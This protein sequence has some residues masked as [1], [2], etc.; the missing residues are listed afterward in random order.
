MQY[1][2]EREAKRSK[3]FDIKKHRR[4]TAPE[5]AAEVVMRYAGTRCKSGEW[6]ALFEL[7]EVVDVM[8]VDQATASRLKRLVIGDVVTVTA[9][10]SIKTRGRSR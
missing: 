6:L 7:G 3:G 1:V 5:K 4:Y 8:P 10:G 2:E 9:Q